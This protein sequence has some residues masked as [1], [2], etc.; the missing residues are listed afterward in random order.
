MEAK[1]A[2]DKVR[3]TEIQVLVASAQKNLLEERMKLCCEL[4]D[5]NVKVSYLSSSMIVTLYL[6]I[7]PVKSYFVPM[8]YSP[9]RFVSTPEL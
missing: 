1:V 2:E 5:G 7:R 6:A 9:R 8:F 4:W 3:T